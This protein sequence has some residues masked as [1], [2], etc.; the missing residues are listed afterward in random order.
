MDAESLLIPIGLFLAI[1]A[2]VALITEVVGLSITNKTV[3]EALKAS[4][5]HLALVTD[6]FQ[7]RRRWSSDA[8]GLLGIALGAALV[9]AALI[10]APG[11]R[12][13]LLQAALLPAFTGAALMGQ[14]WLPKPRQD[15]IGDGAGE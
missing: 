9:V 8:V 13:A 7:K 5:E 2:I 12:I 4:P 1:V 3:R 10:G 11:S 6:K 15:A 14:R